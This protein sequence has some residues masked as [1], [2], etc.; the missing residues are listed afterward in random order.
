MPVFFSLH[1]DIALATLSMAMLLAGS[2]CLSISRENSMSRLMP[3]WR[4]LGYAM[5][6]IAV[7]EWLGIIGISSPVLAGFH[8]YSTLIQGLACIPLL[9]AA[10]IEAPPHKKNLH[11]IGHI[12]IIVLLAMMVILLEPR[13]MTSRSPDEVWQISRSMYLAVRIYFCI[14]VAFFIFCTHKSGIPPGKNAMLPLYL[15]LALSVVMAACYP[16]GIP[17]SAMLQDL[18]SDRFM[19]FAY[20]LRVAL[21]ISLAATLWNLYARALGVVGAIRWWPLL[22]MLCIMVFG[23]TF[24]HISK[25]NYQRI[26]RNNLIVSARNAAYSIP[27]AELINAS[28]TPG[29]ANHPQVADR[30][31]G[32]VR[33]LDFYIG[34]TRVGIDVD[35]LAVE[36][37]TD[38]VTAIIDSVEHP[39]GGLWALTPNPVRELWDEVQRQGIVFQ[40]LYG[41]SL[42]PALVMAPIS[43]PNKE[44]I[45][46][47]VLT[48]SSVDLAK[49]LYVFK[50][51]PLLCL[52]LAFFVFLLLLGSQQ[53]AWLSSHSSNRAEALKLGALGNDLVGVLI[54]RSETIVD[55]NKRLC[56]LVGMTRRELIGRDVA[57][58]F[59]VL[60]NNPILTAEV[61]SSLAEKKHALFEISLRNPGGE[62]IHLMVHARKLNDDAPDDQ[63]IWES[64]DIT[65][66]KNM[67]NQIR[68]HRDSLQMILDSV[69]AAFFVKGADS[70]YRVANQAF[71]ELM[72]CD[73]A[74]D[75]VG[76]TC[77]EIN[78]HASEEVKLHDEI[79]IDMH[80]ATLVYDHSFEVDGEKR[81][82]EVSKAI[83]WPDLDET[84][85]IMVGSLHEFTSRKRAEDAIRAERQFLLQLI[86]A[87]P[88]AVCFLDQDRVIRLCDRDF[89]DEAGVD[90]P[91][92]LIGRPYDEVAPL[93]P[94]DPAEDMR[95]LERGSGHS[96][97]EFELNK[98]GRHR[99]FML[100]RIA[101]SPSYGQPRGLLLAFW[102]TTALVAASRAARNTDRAKA[103]FLS[104]LSHELRT[105][106]N[107]IVGMADLIMD[108]GGADPLQQLY[109]E[110]I[111]KSAKTLRMVMDEVMDIAIID[112]DAK[113]FAVEQSPFP[114]LT[115]TEE[116]A[117][118][119][120]CIV[121][122]WGVDLML[123]Y[124]FALHPVY[125]GDGRRI[126][127]V[128]VQILTQCSRFTA[129]K[130]LVFSVASAGDDTVV[131]KVV[132][133]AEFRPVAE[134]HVSDL[135][136]MLRRPMQTTGD[137]RQASGPGVPSDNIGFPL[138]RRL[139]QAMGG[140]ITVSNE[141]EMIRCEIA[142]D[143][144]LER[145]ASARLAAPDLGD[146]NIYLAI[147]EA[148]RRAAVADC[149]QYAGA[150]TVLVED[151]HDL[152]RQ[153][154]NARNIGSDCD[155]LLMDT[156]FVAPE[157]LPGLLH[158]LQESPDL[159]IAA[160]M[161]IVT[162]RD[163][164]SFSGLEADGLKSLLL[165][166]LCPSELWFK[167][168]Q[169]WLENDPDGRKASAAANRTRTTTRIA[170]QLK[171]SADVL[172]V[173]DNT[174]NQMVAMGILKRLGCN[175]V[176][177]KNGV[178]AVEF[179]NA[180]KV[181]DIIIMDC[182]MPVMDGY[183]AAGLIRRYEKTHSGIKRNIIVALTAN[184]VPG[185]MEKCLA[186]G[187]DGYMAKPITMEIMRDAMLR[188]LPNHV[189]TDQGQESAGK[190]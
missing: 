48:L 92:E 71:A 146:M 185:E 158:E 142:L 35:A 109:A 80:G 98:N 144:Q 121:G 6:I 63:Y 188:H 139:V 17:A 21:S 189:V 50:R 30:L 87:M 157:Q 75:I 160:T 180:G 159:A 60:T 39:K 77:A 46:A 27:G 123:S 166:P 150:K 119:A 140:A 172:L 181:Y 163:L 53:R 141:E 40:G 190:L 187:M 182:L 114:L 54:T 183:E 167:A 128:M 176:L 124:D 56:N 36:P 69:S 79:C 72:G 174:V 22:I 33:Q 84:N 19:S 8:S 13:F 83:K 132:I 23:L 26:V 5:I 10:H 104:E 153:L 37:G 125:L 91:E 44:P 41:P 115:L 100:R 173:E 145:H 148:P 20:I 66:L 25:G 155:L 108:H 130:R 186:S 184:N 94:G 127:Q 147:T 99:N 138:A 62:I 133:R 95:M 171:I 122:A 73:S 165:P 178:E 89:C 170:R 86:N 112:D 32:K 16:P 120:S 45:G 14:A 7:R 1:S 28:S 111:I 29:S 149:M 61:Y 4:Y 43:G 136:D 164:Q 179:I 68:E 129:D 169:L 151:R 42:H 135:E 134:L 118:I 59:D 131:E 96:D 177:A 3:S 106:M 93:G 88:V 2:T 154:R 110:T 78:S 143:M 152:I 58:T 31:F 137:G 90:D 64:V 51:L 12:L 65:K 76:K 97:M 113:R 55:L 11:V 103:A 74:A 161:L 107:G 34:Y 101:L 9:V 47:A 85:Y 38:M 105:P 126:R 81:Y 117:E 102:D 70:R 57:K 156:H 18:A 116:A 175:P 67:E 168:E 15:F 49:D 82:F 24:V 52:P 162:V